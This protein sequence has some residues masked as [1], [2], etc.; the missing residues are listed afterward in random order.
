MDGL[1]SFSFVHAADLH[2][3]CAQYDLEARREDFGRTFQELVNRSLQL[4]PGFLIIA[5][6]IFQQAR[7]LNS[8]LESV[9]QNLRKL[10]D[11]AIPVLAVDGSHDAAPRALLSVRW[12]IFS[13]TSVLLAF[14][15]RLGLAVGYAVENGAWFADVAFG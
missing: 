12:V 7:P 4:K 6:G 15:Y 5:G 11:A 3:G 2:L 10:R 13:V 9:I 14:A 8:T 1:R